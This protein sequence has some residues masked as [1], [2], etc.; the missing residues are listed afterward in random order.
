LE[1]GNWLFPSCSA[2]DI[3][4]KEQFSSR[5][6]ALTRGE[7]THFTLSLNGDQPKVLQF[8][9]SSLAGVSDD[10][11]LVVRDVTSESHLDR[12]KSEFVSTAAH[13]LKTPLA[14]IYGFSEL[15]AAGKV[16]EASKQQVYNAI[17]DQAKQL[18]ALLS[19]LLDLAR[20]EARANNTADRRDCSLTY[21]LHKA[22]E[23]NQRIATCIDIVPCRSDVVVH[24]DE[25]LIIQALYNLFDNA[26]KY[27][28]QGSLISVKTRLAADES[29]V[30]IDVSDT[31]M[32]MTPQQLDQAFQRFFRANPQSNIPGT[33]LGLS[34]VKEVA[35]MHGG[36]VSIASEVDVG[37]CV[38][39]ILPVRK[40][41]R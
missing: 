35:E 34:F 33:G 9:S 7:A 31:G 5:I 12:M 28:A 4:R 18:T 14:S 21:L 10:T 2:I 13:Q 16:P 40:M 20:I 3:Q 29:S 39:L 27:S 22:R 38:T 25:K 8:R 36:S 15:L 11:I 24:G 17:H 23:Y 37:T 41:P 6:S 19:D 26:A 1:I 30:S 32:G